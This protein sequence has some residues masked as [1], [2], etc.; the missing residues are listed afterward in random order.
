[1]W[2]FRS[3]RFTFRRA[4]SD[5]IFLDTR[6]VSERTLLPWHR[7]SARSAFSRLIGAHGSQEEREDA[8][9][10][11]SWRAFAVTLA[12]VLIFWILGATL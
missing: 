2:P 5:E 10:F 4:E 9:D 6:D 8:R 7:R 12:L 3:K 1:M 11:R